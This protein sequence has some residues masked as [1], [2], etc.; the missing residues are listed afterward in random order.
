MKP[1]KLLLLK[2]ECDFSLSERERREGTSKDRCPPSPHCGVIAKLRRHQ[3]D[4]QQITIALN[5]NYVTPNNNRFLL[6]TVLCLPFNNLIQR[7][8]I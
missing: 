8:I 5:A 7:S 2:E 4:L 3:Y 6:E 1:Y